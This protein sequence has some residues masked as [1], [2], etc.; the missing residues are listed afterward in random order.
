MLQRALQ[1]ERKIM[2][3]EKYKG[4]SP[5]QL[6][7]RVW[8][9]GSALHV[10]LGKAWLAGKRSQDPYALVY[11]LSPDTGR[12]LFQL[13]NRRTRTHDQNIQPD[14]NSEFQFPVG[15]RHNT[16]HCSGSDI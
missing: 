6:A 4:E 11:L 13:G 7:L 5:G 3:V 16:G 15:C 14:F 1:G 10:S 8:H 12:G 2:G 9:S